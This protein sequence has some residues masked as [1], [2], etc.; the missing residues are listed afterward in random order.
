MRLI[1]SCSLNYTY[2]VKQPIV[3]ASR[4][5][6]ECHD[7]AA[8]DRTFSSNPVQSSLISTDVIFFLRFRCSWIIYSNKTS[9]FV[10]Q[11]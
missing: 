4:L 8:V 3:N 1:L 5:F 6:Q 11:N 7:R 9:K 10:D 2:P